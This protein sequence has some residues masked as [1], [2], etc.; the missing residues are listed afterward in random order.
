METLWVP[1]ATSDFEARMRCGDARIH[2]PNPPRFLY[3]S[4]A[5]MATNFHFAFENFWQHFG[6]GPAVRRTGSRLAVDGPSWKST[7]SHACHT[8]GIGIG[9]KVCQSVLCV[10]C[11]SAM[12]VAHCLLA[13]HTY[14]F[15]Y[16]SHA[17]LVRPT[18]LVR[19]LDDAAIEL[20]NER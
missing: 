17:D 4:R 9:R 16:P 2:D 11:S 15:L 6:N 10:F 18:V 8:V 13:F 19:R 12:A 1:A 5:A 3:D 14:H 20:A 7:S